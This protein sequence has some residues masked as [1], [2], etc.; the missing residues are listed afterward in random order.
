MRKRI[1]IPA[2]LSCVSLLFAACSASRPTAYLI[3]NNDSDKEV[4]LTVSISG[5]DRNS[6]KTITHTIKPGLQELTPEKFS[7]GSYS[8]SAEADHGAVTIKKQLSLDSDRWIMISFLHDDSLN[9]QKRYGIVDTSVL[10]KINGKYTG[11]DLYSE[12]R[13]PPSL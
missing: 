12:N 10:R 6:M 2:A 5:N 11:L 8:I 4:P 13:R 9:I 7:K 3:V 1:L